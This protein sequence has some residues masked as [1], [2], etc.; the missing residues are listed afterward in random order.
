[1]D[2][3]DSNI[4]TSIKD[5]GSCGACW[6]FAAAAVGE[7]KLVKAGDKDIGIDLS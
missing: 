2:W 1:M 4:I 3:R 7:S 5:Q 6:A